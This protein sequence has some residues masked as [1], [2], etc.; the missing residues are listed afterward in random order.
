VTLAGVGNTTTARRA[1]LAAAG[2][3]FLAVAA[4]ISGLFNQFAQDDFPIIWKNPAVHDLWHSYRFFAQP[5]WPKPFTPDLYRPLAVISYAVQWAIG[6]GSPLLFRIVSYALYAVTTLA[7]FRLARM[8]LPFAVAFAVAALFAVHPVHVEAVAMAV[9]QGELWVGLLSCLAVAWYL[10]VRRAGGPLGARTEL[11]LAGLYLIGCL[12][13]ENALMLPGFLFAAEVL[14]LPA[15]EPLRARIARVRRLFLVLLLV[16]VSFFGIRTLVL[17]GDLLGTFV[18]EALAYLTVGQRALT[19]LAVVPHWFRLTLWPA[20]LQSDYSPGEIVAQT[21]WG[22]DQTLGALLLLL[23]ILAALAAW[24]RHPVITFGIVWWAIALFPVHNVLVPTGIVLAERT[25][26]L[27]S[28]GALLALGGLGALLAERAG[29]RGRLALA[30][31]VGVLLILGTARSTTRHP[32]WADQFGL[33]YDTANRDAVKSYRAHHA[34]AEL[35]YLAGSEGRAEPEY[36][37]AIAY[38]PPRIG[39]VYLDYAN[40]LR[41]RGHCYPAAQLYRKLLEIHPNNM[42]ARASLVACLMNLGQYREARSVALIGV[43]YDWQLSSWQAL[44]AAA[45]SALRASAE[46]GSVKLT[47]VNDSVATYMNIGTKP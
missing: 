33:W 36:R 3:V 46:P 37:L 18:A 4:S 34:L 21:A 8:L 43:S 10:R 14:L 27:P 45:D 5:Y 2:L 6:G 35:Y 44:R 26:F 12:F 9:N 42:A 41:L 11:G 7:V 25:L 17:S 19:M 32:V 24:R 23:T 39:Q 1:W 28:I 20:H 47:L 38:S 29:A 16:A 31:A 30:S 13:K 22:S 15:G 40:K